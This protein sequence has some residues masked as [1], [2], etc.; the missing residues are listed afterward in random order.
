MTKNIK[1]KKKK[2]QLTPNFFFFFFLYKKQKKHGFNQIFF[3]WCLVRFLFLFIR[4]NV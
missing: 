4:G 3:S 2:K 1:K